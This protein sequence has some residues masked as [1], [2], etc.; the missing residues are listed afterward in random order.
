MKYIRLTDGRIIDVSLFDEYQTNDEEGESVFDGFGN[1]SV[2]FPAED[3]LKQSDKI[4]ELC[5]CFVAVDKNGCLCE[6]P[7]VAKGRG[8]KSFC[9][10]YKANHMDVDCYLAILTDKG[11]IFVAK[12]NDKGEFE[13]L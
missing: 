2:Y 11:L 10:Y 3:I 5:D 12:R 4:E 9:N 8:F 6:E 13:L 7:M 1:G